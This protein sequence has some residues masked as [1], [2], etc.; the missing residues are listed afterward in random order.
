MIERHSQKLCKLRYHLAKMSDPLLD[1]YK[2]SMVLSGVGDAMGYKNGKFEFNFVGED[3][4]KEVKKLGGISKL[5]IKLPD[6]RVSDDTVLH[7]ATAESLARKSKNGDKEAL[8][9]DIAKSYKEGMHDM[10]GRAAGPTTMQACSQL[11]PERPKG[12]QVPFNT[13][14]GGCGAAMRSMC[15]GLRYPRPEDLDDLIA[16]SVESG[17]MT[18]NHPTGYLG[19]LASALFTAYS[20]QGKPVNSWGAGLMSVLPKALK[21]VESQEIDVAENQEHWGYFTRK[22]E[23][24]LRVRGVTDG[25]ADPT[26]PEVYGVK[27]RDEFYKSWSF[28]GWG[29]ASGHDAPLISYDALLGSGNSWEKLCERAMLHGGDNDSTGVIAGACYGAMYGFQGVP[30]N[31]YKKLEYRDRLEKV[32][33]QLYQLAN[34]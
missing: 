24:Y 18:H 32:A 30:E 23:D 34:N 27:E 29:G 17:R 15:I 6:W 5:K 14:G 16:V 2:A 33:E 20:I 7:L 11:R 26:F 4:H 31:H 21:Y 3:I 9:L 25:T 10:S 1:R 19:S 13:R 12:Y 22:W 28:A 8:Y